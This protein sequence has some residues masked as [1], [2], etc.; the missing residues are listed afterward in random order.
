M[1]LTG[2]HHH[3]GL[4]ILNRVV[5]TVVA[6]GH[7]HG[8]G[9]GGERQQL[10]TKA[11]AEHRDVGFEHLLDRLDRVVARLGVTRTVGQE[12]TVRIERQGF[13][14]RRLCRKHGDSATAGDQ[15]AQDVVLHAVIE[16]DDM[17]GQLAGGNLGMAVIL[18]APDTGAPLVTLL[19]ADFL[20]QIHALEA[21]EAARQLQRFL[22]GRIATSQDAAVLR[23]LLTQ[24]TGQATSI[25]A[26]DGNGAIGLEVVRQGLLVA[27]VAGNQRQVANNQT[28]SPDFPGLGILRRGTSVADMRI[29]QGYDL[30][31]VG[32]IGEDFLIAGH[33]GVEHHLTNGLPIGA[34]GFAA[35]DAA[36]GKS[37]N[38]WR[39]GWLSQETSRR[40]RLEQTQ[41]V[42]KRDDV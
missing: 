15:H 19:D 32:R 1:V 18:Q 5:R 40:S 11:D 20:R 13:A 4:Q 34:D 24:D 33:G 31:G 7:L 21:G 10:V 8:R 37:Q 12:D 17:V 16:G 6:V 9:A 3:T 2:D 14:G 35:K 23:T 30:L 38:G 39:K 36:I 28:R 26:G 29:G 42:K 41:I 22:F 27:P 25:D